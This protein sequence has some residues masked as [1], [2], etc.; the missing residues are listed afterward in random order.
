M[1]F[2]VTEGFNLPS[3]SYTVI[4]ILLYR[5]LLDF[6]YLEDMI[7]LSHHRKVASPLLIV[8]VAEPLESMALLRQ[9]SKTQGT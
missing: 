2:R 3:N 1:R 9:E 7:R 4:T 6:A 5:N 8:C